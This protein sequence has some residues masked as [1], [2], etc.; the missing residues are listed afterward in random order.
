M[1]DVPRSEAALGSVS[2][3]AFSFP[4]TVDEHA[5]R[6]VATG[7]VLMGL[8]S[9]FVS[10][11]ILVPLAVGFALRVGWGPRLSPLAR[12]VTRRLVG[13]VVPT[14][15]QVAGAPKRFAQG[16]GLAFSTTA[17]VL[18]ATGLGSASLVV[19]AMLVVAASLE[20]GLGFCLGCKMYALAQRAGLISEDACPDCADIY[21]RVGV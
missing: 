10:Q 12:L 8:G 1:D 16:V 19:T 20:A 17:L 13:N 9:L 18:W 6:L 3:W 5:A 14:G 7:V 21:R 11:W 4:D 15:N 2:R